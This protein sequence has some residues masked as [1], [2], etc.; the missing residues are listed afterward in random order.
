MHMSQALSQDIPFHLQGNFAPVSEEVTA[1]D[2]PVE[3]AIPPQ[4][5]GLYVRNSA[6]PVTGE[7]GHWFMGDGMVH[8]VRIEDGRALWY[9]NRYVQTPYLENPEIQRMSASGVDRTVSK[10]NTH[11]IGHAGRILALEEGSFPYVLDRELA[12]IGPDDFGGRLRTA[13]TAHPKICPVTGELLA[14]GYGQA[15]PYLVYHRFSADGKLV[16]STDI[17]VP[18]PT[19]MHDFAITETKALF[20]DLPV[21]FDLELAMSGSMPY[22][23]SDD[24]GA[25]IGIM[26]RDG[27]DADVRWFEVDPCYI[28]HGLNAYDDGDEVVF[29]ACRSSEV[30]RQAGQ[31]GGGEGVLSLHRFRFDLTSGNVREETVDDRALEFPRVADSMVGQHHRFGF[32]VGLAPTAE[33]TPGFSGLVKYD[34]DTGASARHEFGPGRNSAEPCFVR[35][36]ASDPRSDEGWVVSYVHDENTGQ[37]ELSILDAQDFE[38]TPVARIALPQRVPYGFHGSWIPER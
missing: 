7:S 22:H 9:R 38:A 13:L 29:D 34:F 14:F 15:A 10:A 33:A 16:Q 4:L 31:M 24:Y 32:F 28:F 17:T 11:V 19:M 21:V 18:G 23:W 6:N 30:W 5:S 35:A 3:G 8:G 26:P 12:T 37:T 25:R 36:E 20:L 1:T 27:S 2:L